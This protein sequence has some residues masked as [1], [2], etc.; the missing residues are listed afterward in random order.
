M[1]ARE[2]LEQ[3]KTYPVFSN[4][5]SEGRAPSGK[6]RPAETEQLKESGLLDQ[7]LGQRT[8]MFWNALVDARA[9]GANQHEAE[10]FALPIIL[11]PAEGEDD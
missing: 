8:E 5:A 4:L 1:R 7:L 3:L 9:A 10:E 2:P 6:Y 11:L